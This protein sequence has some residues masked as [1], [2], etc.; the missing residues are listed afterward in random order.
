MNFSEDYDRTWALL[1]DIAEPDDLAVLV[2]YITDKGEGRAALDSDVKT[3]LVTAKKNRYYAEHV[4]SKIDDEI[5]EFGGNS[6][7]NVFRSL[8]GD[9]PIAY[10]EVATDVAKHLK[11]S[12][13]DNMSVVEIEM[14]ILQKILKDSIEKM[15]EAERKE[16]LEGLGVTDLSATGPAIIAALLK[17]GKLGGIKTYHLA[18]IVA[19]A[20]AKAITGSGLKLSTNAMITKGLSVALGPVGWVL[21][22]IWTAV[23]LASP[24]L[25]V[26]LPCVVQVAYIRQKAI[27]ALTENRCDQ[28]AQDNAP[29]AKFCGACGNKLDGPAQAKAA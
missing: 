3:M 18:V 6:L 9:G 13:T 11:A 14:A 7:A 28:C 8:K 20:V 15:S 12:I 10:K 22:G 21:T 27:A 25:R 26:T 4:R 17:A 19:N 16:L 2:D 1:R 29:Q 23:D 24:A 5:R